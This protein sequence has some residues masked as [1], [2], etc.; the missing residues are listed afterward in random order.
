MIK[1]LKTAER[2]NARLMPLHQHIA[3]GNPV[4]RQK[5]SK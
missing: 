2:A 5:I 1:K 4:R 3:T